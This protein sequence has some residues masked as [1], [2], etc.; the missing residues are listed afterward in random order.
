MDFKNLRCLLPGLHGGV[1]GR[2]LADIEACTET[3]VRLV[4]PGRHGSGFSGSP[5]IEF[6][7]D[8]RGI[9]SWRQVTGEERKGYEDDGTR[10]EVPQG[11]GES[12]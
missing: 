1:C 4:C 11:E 7:Q 9:V 12:V 6:R 5:K 10:I 8:Q 2:H 3:T